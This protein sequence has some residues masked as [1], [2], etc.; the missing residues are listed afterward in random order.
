MYLRRGF[1]FTFPTR[2]RFMIRTIALLFIG[3]VMMHDYA[4]G[5]QNAGANGF[6]TQAQFQSAINRLS[7]QIATLGAQPSATPS[8][9]DRVAALEEGQQDI[10]DVQNEQG[11][12]L[13]QIAMR[14]ENGNYHWRFDTNSQS[15]RNEFRRAMRSAIPRRGHFVIHNLS[16]YDKDIVVNGYQFRVI[17]GGTL[18][19][20]VPVGTVSSRVSGEATKYWRVDVYNDHRQ[21]VDLRD[22]YWP[23]VVGT[24]DQVAVY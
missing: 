6:V 4:Y 11:I 3:L 15:A 10:R 21:D 7:Q 17:G 16:N 13:G 20:L 23:I 24:I 5:Q 2:E 8:L 12:V 19:L 18:D 9:E 1:W 14:G 22:G